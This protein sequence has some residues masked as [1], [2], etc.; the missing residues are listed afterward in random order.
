MG[1]QDSLTAMALGRGHYEEEVVDT[2]PLDPHNSQKYDRKGYPRNPQTRRHERDQVRAANEV[3]QVT[4][5]VE[6]ALA[7]QL[8]AHE[9]MREKNEETLTGLRL[10]EV[11]RAVLVAGVW[12]VMGLRRR[13]L[14]YR[15][16]AETGLLDLV[17]QERAVRGIPRML[18]T[19]LPAV[20]AYHALDMMSFF[21]ET[22]LDALYDEEEGALTDQ[23]KS[24][25]WGLNVARDVGFSYFTLHCRLF[26]VLQQLHLI[27]AT[28]WIPTPLS[29]IPFSSASPLSMPP[30]P[31]LSAGSVA[32]FGVALFQTAAPLLFL[33]AQ[34]QFKHV[35]SRIIY[36]PIYKTLPRPTGDSMF[37]GLPISA[38]TMEYDSPDCSEPEQRPN[39][40]SD[41]PTLRALEGL[42]ALAAPV[43]EEESGEDEELAQATLI[44]FD[45][46][47]TE[48]A[49]SSLGTWSAELRSANE[50]STPPRVAYRVTGLTMLPPIM[51]TEGLREMVASILTLPVEAYVMRQIGRTFGASAGAGTSDMYPVGPRV[52]GA[53]NLL[54]VFTAQLVATGVVWAGFTLAT[55]WWAARRRRRKPAPE[56]QEESPG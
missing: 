26:A 49:E 16:Y 36:R 40:R 11:G 2:G 14:L 34:G 33:L 5:V 4:G 12:G 8:K 9:S 27:P 15:P 23:E 35:L 17:R 48:R 38:P 56:D 22:V 6:D 42:P 13:I 50:P 45:V 55:Q 29:F 52:H 19:G 31:S 21:C 10:M 51:A 24:I 32:K 43:E 20:G 46:E 37:S 28:R 53:G 39:H 30:L 44:S 54:A 41:E 25:K 3:M 7:A 18:L 47:A 1:R